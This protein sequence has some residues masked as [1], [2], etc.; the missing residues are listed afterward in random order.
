MVGSTP[1]RLTPAQTY[2]DETSESLAAIVIVN[3]NSV[4]DLIECLESLLRLDGERWRIIVVDNASPDGI[5]ELYRWVSSGLPFATPALNAH[6]ADTPRRS[7][8]LSELRGGQAISEA[9]DCATIHL[10]RA[11]AN[12]G[13]AAG[14]NLGIRAALGDPRVGYVWLLNPDTLVLPG[15]GEALVK[16]FAAHPAAGIAGSTLVYYHLPTMVQGA[17]VI[18]DVRTTIGRQIFNGWPLDSLPERMPARVEPTYAIG[19]SMMVSR[20]FIEQVGEM[21]EAYFLYF[22]EMDWTER[23]RHRFSIGW[24]RNS[25]VY[26]KEGGTIGTSTVADPSAQS[27]YFF[28]RALLLFYRRHHPLLIAVALL[29]VAFNGTRYLARRKWPLVAAVARGG[30]GGL[31]GK[32]P[33]SGRR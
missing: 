21:T 13:F 17:G 22:E 11:P 6:L 31:T 25:I 9:A 32:P 5:E 7:P 28:T 18:Y 26:H 14:N 1:S 2:A 19:A 33:Q 8:R 16:Y 3:Y 10:L 12:R 30:W 27:V 20:H 24:A 4:D 29:R 15:A 23:N